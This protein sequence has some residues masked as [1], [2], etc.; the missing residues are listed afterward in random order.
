[1]KLALIGCGAMGQL[2]ASLAR[3]GGDEIGVVFSS[4]NTGQTVEE[5]SA[6]LKGHD[7][8]IDFSTAG[9]VV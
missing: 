6:H 2:V 5:F 4:S 9:A 3:K 8:A 1:M 7:A